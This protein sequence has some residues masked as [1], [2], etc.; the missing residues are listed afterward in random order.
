MPEVGGL[1]ASTRRWEVAADIKALE[2]PNERFT[3]GRQIHHEPYFTSLDDFV[4]IALL[5]VV[6]LYSEY[7]VGMH[8]ISKDGGSKQLD[9]LSRRG[10]LYIDECI[11]NWFASPKDSP[12]TE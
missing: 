9:Y 10:E 4:L 12:V 6:Y 8:F 3:E 5:V 2:V 1:E 7:L 11:S